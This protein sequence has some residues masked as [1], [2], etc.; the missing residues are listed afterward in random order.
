VLPAVVAR[1]IQRGFDVA[2][3]IVGPVVGR[4]GDSERDAIV[5]DAASLGVA[6]RV[7]LIGPV[8]LE[9]LLPRYADYDVFVLPT[10]P[11]EGVP[12]VLLEAMAAGLP[13]VTSSVAGIPSLITNQ[14]NGLL[15]DEPSAD[16]VAG[17]IERLLNDGALRRRVIENGY[18]TA[19][20]HTLQAQ[21]ARMMDDVSRRLGVTLRQPA[22]SPA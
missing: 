6:D 14:H 22:V 18:A 8:P 19:R 9:R 4:P 13:V 15:V 7:S 21:A 2:I 3:D 1:L 5:A 20:A 16:A 17:A 10:L 12:R 11:G